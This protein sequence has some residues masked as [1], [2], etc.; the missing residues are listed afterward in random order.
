MKEED[1]LDS[2]VVGVKGQERSTSSKVD[3]KTL[4]LTKE[5]VSKAHK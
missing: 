1:L 3:M 4:N 5:D 2:V